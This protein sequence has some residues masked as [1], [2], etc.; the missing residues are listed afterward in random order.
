MKVGFINI[1]E[2]C[3]YTTET[4]PYIY[5]HYKDI[6][7]SEHLDIVGLAEAPLNNKIGDS[8]FINNL[9]VDLDI[10]YKYSFSSDKSFIGKYPYSGISILSR[11]PIEEKKIIK[12]YNPNISITRPDGTIWKTHDKYIQKA[13]LKIDHNKYLTIFNT[14]TIP[15]TLFGYSMDS[16]HGRKIFSQLNSELKRSQKPYIVTGDFNT[17]EVPIKDLISE[18]INI[19][20]RD[21][22]AGICPGIYI[23]S[24]SD[25]VTC[26]EKI[27]QSKSD[28][29]LISVT[30]KL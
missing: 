20:S 18:D 24:S 26:E 7:K 2:G 14:H 16:N 6:L 13:L 10:P 3:D 25:V 19:A 4:H 23:L 21:L 30:I 28:C 17:K 9:S 22:Q 11:Y 12:Y 5:E 15:I 1:Y 29:N 8:D 27:V